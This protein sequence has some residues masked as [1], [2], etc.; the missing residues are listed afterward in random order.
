MTS[1]F[2]GNPAMCRKII[3]TFEPSTVSKVMI[4]LRSVREEKQITQVNSNVSSGTRG[5]VA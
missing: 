3:K 4:R 1:V 5:F 2:L